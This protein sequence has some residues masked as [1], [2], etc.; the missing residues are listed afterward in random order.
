[1]VDKFKNIP[2]YIWRKVSY[3]A[4]SIVMLVLLGMGVIT[5]DAHDSTM[6]F[7]PQVLAAIGFAFAG[8]KANRGS[9][10]SDP[11]PADDAK[12]LHDMGGEDLSGAT[13]SLD[14]IR[15]GL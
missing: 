2:A 5:Q 8:T 1:M 4:L 15:N 10:M 14:D 3:F 13:R 9:D 6:E 7:V 12:A 11:V